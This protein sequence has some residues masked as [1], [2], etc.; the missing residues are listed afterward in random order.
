MHATGK[1]VRHIAIYHLLTDGQLM[2]FLP[3][4]F[5]PLIITLF[6]QTMKNDDTSSRT[7]T[8]IPLLRMASICEEDMYSAN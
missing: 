6:D 7:L 2:F 4:R 5:R 8:S 3:A 1:A